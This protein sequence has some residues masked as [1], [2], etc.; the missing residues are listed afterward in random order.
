MFVKTLLQSIPGSAYIKKNFGGKKP[1]LRAADAWLQWKLG[2]LDSFEKIDWSRVDRLVFVC[3]GNICR[4][5]YGELLV[6]EKGLETASCGL[7]A[8]QDDVSPDGARSAARRARR[9]LEAHRAR[10]FDNFDWRPGDLALVFE[11]PHALETEQRL[12]QR[13]VDSPR[14]QV[15]LLGLWARPRRPHIQDPYSLHADYFD[16]CYAL[17]EDSLSRLLEE[18]KRYVR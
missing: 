17:I 5:P 13:F 1:A 10:H 15:A 4:S 18:R 3:L 9:S 2:N 14:P 16:T 12:K 6:R 7:A 11:I 8:R